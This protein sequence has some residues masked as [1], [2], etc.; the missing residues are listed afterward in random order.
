MLRLAGHYQ[1]HLQED[2]WWLILSPY[3]LSNRAAATVD[4]DRLHP[5]SPAP[6]VGLMEK[7]ALR[8]VRPPIASDKMSELGLPL[9]RGQEQVQTELA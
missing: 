9:R 3:A 1:R 5:L 2:H 4:I 7:D 8:Q 6:S